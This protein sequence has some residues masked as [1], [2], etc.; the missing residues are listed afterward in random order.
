M[1]ANAFAHTRMHT[2]IRT[3]TMNTRIRTQLHLTPSMPLNIVFNM[4]QGHQDWVFQTCWLNDERFVSGGRDGKLIVWRADLTDPGL[5]TD[6]EPVLTKDTRM[7]RRHK[8]MCV[9]NFCN[10]VLQMVLMHSL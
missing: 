1:H 3:Y 9:D 4:V 6:T 5:M 2:Y 8:C 10:H 7:V